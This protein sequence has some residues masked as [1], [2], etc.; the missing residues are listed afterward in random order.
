[1][2]VII[3]NNFIIFIYFTVA[4]IM[5]KISKTKIEQYVINKVKEKRIQSRLSQ[6]ELADLL[7]LSA[8][9][10]GKIE[11][12]KYAA[13]YNLNHINALAKIF[14]CSPKEL[15]PTNYIADDEK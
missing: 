8:G 14:N 7:N 3:S 11:S 9:F 12:N 4:K 13:K 5:N 6:A 15:L 2:E 1:M 10:I